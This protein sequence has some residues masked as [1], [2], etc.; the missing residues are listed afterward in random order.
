ME[1]QDLLRPFVHL[2]AGRRDVNTQMI[3]VEAALNFPTVNGKLLSLVTQ[4]VEAV[5]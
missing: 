2:V 4:Q 3:F 5:I 1:K